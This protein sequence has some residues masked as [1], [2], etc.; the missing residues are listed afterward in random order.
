MGRPVDLVVPVKSLHLAKSRLRGPL[1]DGE[2]AHRRLALAM[3]RDTIAAAAAAVAVRRVLAICSDPS[4]AQVLGADGVEVVADEPDA[5]LNPALRHGTTLL[6]AHAPTAVTG[7]LHA[8]LPALRP[9]ELDAALAAF[10]EAHAARA[11]CPDRAGTGTTLLLAAPGAELDPRF[12]H[13]SASAHTASGAVR[14]EGPWPSLRCDVDTE[15]D[16]AEAARLGLG[17]HTSGA[18]AGHRRAPAAN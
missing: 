15:A 9:H 4:A 8:D 10:A 6:R 14:L 3:A 16:L 17:R 5:G 1:T 2:S 7:A 12:G 11:F 18:L 13:G